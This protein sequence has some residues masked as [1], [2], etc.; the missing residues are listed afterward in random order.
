MRLGDVCAND[1]QANEDALSD[2]SRILSAYKKAKG[3][4]LNR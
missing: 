2:G 4:N 1:R 3:R